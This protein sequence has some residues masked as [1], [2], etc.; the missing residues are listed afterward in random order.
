MR[1]K[2]VSVVLMI[3][4]MLAAGLGA[5]LISMFPCLTAAF[6]GSLVVHILMYDRAKKGTPAFL[7]AWV[8]GVVCA[9]TISWLNSLVPPLGCVLASFL[10]GV[11]M[12]FATFFREDKEEVD[13]RNDTGVVPSH[14]R[15]SSKCHSRS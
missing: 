14:S 2:S 11:V 6:L 9:S 8:S 7:V 13:E 15:N 5:W 12:V 10:G 4:G 1:I 3:G